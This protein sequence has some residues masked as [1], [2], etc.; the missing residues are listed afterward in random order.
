MLFAEGLEGASEA[1]Y[2]LYVMCVVHVGIKSRLPS[3]VMLLFKMYSCSARPEET[4]RAS[5][6]SLNTDFIGFGPM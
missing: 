4:A 6:Y 3:L 1:V 5:V 2:D